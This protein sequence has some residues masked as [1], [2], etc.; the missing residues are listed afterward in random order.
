[1]TIWEATP[2]ATPTLSP[3]LMVPM[4]DMLCAGVPPIKTLKH[5]GT[6]VIPMDIL[7]YGIGIGPTGVGVLHT[8]GN[9]RFIPPIIEFANMSPP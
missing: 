8:S 2:P 3:L 5:G 4:V 1:M 9:P 6:R 7:G